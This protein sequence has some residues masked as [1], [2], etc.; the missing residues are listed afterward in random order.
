[1]GQGQPMAIIWTILVVLPYTMLHTKFQGH[2]S[3]GSG[4]EDFLRFLPYMGM[5]AMLVIWP[6]P[7]EQLFFL[8]GPG[9]CIWNLVAIGPVVSEEKSF[10]IVDGGQTDDGACLYY[11]LPR[12]LWLRWAITLTNVQ[13]WDIDKKLF[14]PIRFEFEKQCPGDQSQ[15]VQNIKEIIVTKI[16]LW[17]GKVLISFVVQILFY[18]DTYGA[19][20][21]EICDIKPIYHPKWQ[22]LNTVIPVLMHSMHFFIFYIFTFQSVLVCTQMKC[23]QKCKIKHQPIRSNVKVIMLSLWLKSAG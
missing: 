16:F 10:E 23:F 2:W 22:F 5:A 17:G 13:E 12:S 8:K 20:Y 3:T 4:E 21:N 14:W 9:E 11:K 19:H 1:M 15:C 7:F 18:D 6:R